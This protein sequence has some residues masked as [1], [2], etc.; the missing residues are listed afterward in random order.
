MKEKLGEAPSS[1]EEDEGEV[2]QLTGVDLRRSSGEVVLQWWR[3]MGSS[4]L[5]WL[6]RER[7]GES[8]GVRE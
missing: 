3:R 8:E 5:A 1:K 6:E 4:S 2:V 7:V